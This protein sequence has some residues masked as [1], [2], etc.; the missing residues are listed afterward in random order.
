MSDKL[1][2]HYNRELAYIRKMAAEFAKSNPGLAEHLRIS[3]DRVED[4]HV[5]RLIEAFAYINARTRQKIDDDFPEITDAYLDVLYPHYLAPFPSSAIVQ[6]KLNQGQ[7]ELT[8]GHKI[9]RGSAILTEPVDGEPCRFRTCYPVTLWPMAVRDAGFYNPSHPP[10][11]T[12]FNSRAKA[13]LRIVLKSYSDKIHFSQFKLG[14]LRFFL[15]GHVPLM[16]QFYESLLNNALGIAVTAGSGD[17][18]PVVLPK[19]ALQPVGFERDEGLIDYTPR[20]FLGYR[21]LSEYAVFPEKFL[22]VDLHGLSANVL[23]KVGSGP[24][25]ELYVFLDRESRELQDNV[26][27]ETLALGC[28]P[29]ANLFKKRAEPIRLSHRQSEY[30]IVPDERLPA[31]FEIHS[32]DRV[33]AVSP[34]GDEVEYLP[35]YSIKH[36]QAREEQRKFWYAARRPADDRGGDMDSGTELFLSIVDLDFQP[37]EVDEWTLSIETTC[38]NRDL[39]GR[40]NFGG[41]EPRLQLEHGSPLVDLLCMTAPT[42]THRQELGHAAQWRLISHLSLGHLSLTAREDG[43]EAL[44]EILRLYN[45]RSSDEFESVITGLRTLR[46]RRVVGRVG[47]PV[48]AGF[49]RGVEVTLGFDEEKFVGH[50]LFLFAS[51]LERFLALYSSINSFTKTVATTNRRESPLRSWPP[52]AGEKVLL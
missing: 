10:P 16:H 1:L 17:K 52:R 19:T 46:T 50:G 32:V 51:V 18:S 33:T 23:D 31:H 20:S 47:G 40:F 11:K 5:S 2:A 30:R 42:R 45:L 27:A 37:A 21:L 28:T 12:E 3:Q 7:F 48:S 8:D 41:G 35:F 36:Q 43:A 26:S 4:P 24:E 25:L 34:D 22:F 15:N 39:P 49:C 6:F 14:P 38:V 29:I 9:G 13:V 44:R